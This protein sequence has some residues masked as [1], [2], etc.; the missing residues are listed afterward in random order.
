MGYTK[1]QK[2]ASRMRMQRRAFSKSLARGAAVRSFGMGLEFG[3]PMTP[4]LAMALA[5]ILGSRSM[6]KRN[7]S[8]GSA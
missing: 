5:S 2:R 1:K 4:N 8:R 3:N 6:V 7:G